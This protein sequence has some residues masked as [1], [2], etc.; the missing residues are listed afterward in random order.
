MIKNRIDTVREDFN[1]FTRGEKVQILNSIDISM[2]KMILGVETDLAVLLIKT[3]KDDTAV[4][5]Y[6]KK[7]I[8]EAYSCQFL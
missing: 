6:I 3:N 8:M 5:N 1:L 7:S 2:V 4:Q